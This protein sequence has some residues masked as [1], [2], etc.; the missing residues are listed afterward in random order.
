MQVIFLGTSA[1]VPTKDR[2]H[3][4]F[5]LSYKNEGLLFDCGE[6]TQRQI[7]IAGIKPSKITRIFISHF[8]GDHILG[9][10]GLL[11]TLSASQYEGKLRIY[12]PC[13]I[14]KMIR[15]I[16]E[17]FVYDNQLEIEINEVE[18]LKNNPFIKTQDFNIEAYEL[19]HRIYCL[20]YR[21]IENDR[22]RIDLVKAKKLGMSSGP[23]LGRLQ[24]GET[25]THKG[26]KITPDDVAYSVKGKKIGYIADTIM[27]DNCL[28]IAQ[29]ADILIS[30]STH[31]SKDDDKSRQYK[32]FNARQAA[33]VAHQANAKTLVLTHFSQRY[34][35][36]DVVLNDAKDVFPNTIASYDFM[37]IK[38]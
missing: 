20:G 26:K 31:A 35:D 30:E 28:K 5:Y 29:D 17:I 32:H 14:E 24:R 15:S 19:D 4:S 1:M 9:L 27:T 38:L 36:I 23:L 18:P 33:Y 34:K 2:N 7:K 10:P 16:M 8:H 3:F 13:G 6:G 21:F 11:Q 25:I 22:L 37:K 12:G